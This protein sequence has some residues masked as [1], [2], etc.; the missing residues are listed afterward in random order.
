M[1]IEYVNYTISKIN[2]TLWA[3]VDGDFPI[4]IPLSQVGQA[5]PM[6]YPTPPATTNISIELDGQKVDYSN[7]TQSY[8]NMIHYTYMGNWPMIIYILQPTSNSFTMTIHYQHPIMQANGTYQFLYDLNISP[9]LSSDSTQSTA[10]FTVFFQI[11]AS[12]IHVYTV[13]GDSSVDRD[14][15]RTPIN[16][17]TS[18][19]NSVQGITFSISSTYSNPV[20][21]DELI[22]F[23][24]TKLQIPEFTPMATA[25]PIIV[26][27][28]TATF[29]VT[30][31]KK[32]REESKV[33]SPP[34]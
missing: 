19:V 21:G 4:Q 2:G 10:H 16:F 11:N 20:S 33:N 7:Y 17:T 30:F 12:D 23:Q 18:N 25:Y 32:R 22:T 15:N 9:Y 3:T 28:A 6:L 8:P 34:Q 26:G 31:Q 1:P 27:V 24:E 5:L 29:V 14:G 13:P